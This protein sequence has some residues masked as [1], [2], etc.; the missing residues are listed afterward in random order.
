MLGQSYPPSS[1]GWLSLILASARMEPLAEASPDAQVKI[2]PARLPHSSSGVSSWILSSEPRSASRVF[3]SFI[4]SCVY[5]LC[6]SN[7]TVISWGEALSLSALRCVVFLA[8]RMCSADGCSV[9]EWRMNVWDHH[10]LL[11][12][13]LCPF[14]GVVFALLALDMLLAPCHFCLG[15]AAVWGFPVCEVALEEVTHAHQDEL[16]SFCSEHRWTVSVICYFIAAPMTLALSLP[17]HFPTQSLSLWRSAVLWWC[18]QPQLDLREISI[19]KIRRGQEPRLSAHPSFSL[20]G[21]CWQ[22]CLLV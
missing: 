6:T 3:P 20:F 1:N 9:S 14:S 15:R 18:T 13:R 21:V 22:R 11:L 16:V 19:L 2:I 17:G 8:W 4:S 7:W 5:D 10:I 12:A